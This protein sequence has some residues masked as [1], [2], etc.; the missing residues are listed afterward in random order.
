MHRHGDGQ[1]KA[2]IGGKDQSESAVGRCHVR[3]IAQPLLCW[4]LAM[5]F[6]TV[7]AA[8]D[9]KVPFM[10]ARQGRS[11]YD[12]LRRER[13]TTVL[14]LGT[15]FGASAAYMAAAVVANGGGRVTTVDRYHFNSGPAPPP[16]Q[17][18]ERLGLAGTIDF[19]RI[20]HS[21]YT[22]WLKQQ[23]EGLTDRAG[24]AQPTY[25]FCYL[26]G[27]HD[28]NIDGLAVVLVERLLRPGAWLLLD[29]LDWTYASSA[30]PTPDGLSDEE[31]SVPHIRA[32]F[33]VVIRGHPNFD[34][35]RIEDGVW[36]WARKRS[37]PGKRRLW[38]RG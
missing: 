12:H 21:S 5:R 37:S 19:V 30:S 36:G 1:R 22:W 8:L 16:E 38:R 17:T 34:R 24:N 27:A 26:D 20:D 3:I 9:G 25:D 33:D 10:T 29:D 14:E 32:V 23:I 4:N 35:L 28:W 11:V 31:Q 2:L 6:E 18:A 7:A 15:A 13:A